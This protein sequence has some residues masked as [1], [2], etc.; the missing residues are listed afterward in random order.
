MQTFLPYADFAKS[1]SVLDDLRLGNQRGECVAILSA[2]CGLNRLQ[3][4]AVEM[5]RGYQYALSNY[6]LC[7]CAE[8]QDRGFH[9]LTHERLEFYPDAPLP[10]WLGMPELHAS[11]RSNLLRKD[12]GW[13][14]QW[15]WTEPPTLRYVWPT[16]KAIGSRPSP[17]NGS[18][19][20]TPKSTKSAS[21]T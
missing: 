9:D 20:W 19:P 5:W 12:H 10:W 8:W 2:L 14:S 6:A 15:K 16:V 11:H 1:A 13:Y 3:H 7:I 4:S 21:T 17:A 18:G